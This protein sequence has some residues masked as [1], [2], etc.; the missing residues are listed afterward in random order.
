MGRWVRFAS[1]MLLVAAF[2]LV[3]LPASP[4]HALPEYEDDA[5]SASTVDL[6]SSTP[7]LT[8]RAYGTVVYSAL[9]VNETPT[10]AAVTLNLFRDVSNVNGVSA[11][12]CWYKYTAAGGSVFSFC[13]DWHQGGN[14]GETLRIQETANL[15]DQVTVMCAE[16]RDGNGRKASNCIGYKSFPGVVGAP[17]KTVSVIRVNEKMNGFIVGTDGRVYSSWQSSI[18]G[19]WGGWV[20]VGSGGP[21]FVGTPFVR[22]YDD[23]GAMT[24]FVTGSDGRLYTS[25]QP[26]AG[27]AWVP[28]VPI[29][30]NAFLAGSPAIVTA[31]N[32][33]MNAFATSADGRVFTT[34]Q[35]SPGSGWTTLV[36]VG[37]ESRAFTGRPAA[38]A[39]GSS[40]AMAAF[41]TDEDSRTYTSWQPSAGSSWHSWVPVGDGGSLSGSPA[42]V[43]GVG[44]KMSGYEIGNDGRPYTSWQ[45]STGSSWVPWVQF[46]S[47][48]PRFTGSPA[49]RMY[50][51]GGGAMTAFATGTDG[52]VYTSWQPSAGS[53]WVAWTQ[54]GNSDGISKKSSPTIIAD[55]TGAMSA[56]V[57]G[58]DNAV[59]TS[60]QTSR[61]SGWT[62]WSRI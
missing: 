7:V 40:G 10:L 47:G 28:W 52:H 54:I 57:L 11:Q 50:D 58:V 30:G 21:A 6:S 53:T 19:G 15:E 2:A 55:P 25:W 32:G 36:P 26:T 14:A 43:M 22:T 17:E 33:T 48:G 20:Q 46:G 16:V 34:W 38:L 61:G 3:G 23:R 56:F 59:Y 44:S 45:P 5:F 12:I 1:A 4:A 41:V 31:L 29:G 60:W 18:G 62:A 35:P 39:S 9:R 51:G 8:A 24:A 13:G 27:S 42:V 49:V 37:G